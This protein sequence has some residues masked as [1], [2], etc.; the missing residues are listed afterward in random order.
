M[1]NGPSGLALK[2]VSEICTAETQRTRRKEF[3]IN[4]VSDLCELR[5]SAVNILNRKAGIAER[6]IAG[7]P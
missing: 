7:E 6:F 4:K 5:A 3:L 1:K 2:Q